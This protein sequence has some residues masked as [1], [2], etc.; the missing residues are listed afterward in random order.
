MQVNTGRMALLEAIAHKR[1]VLHQFIYA[2]RTPPPVYSP[3]E[4][5]SRDLLRAKQDT[6]LVVAGLES[7]RKHLV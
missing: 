7:W 3:W 6:P 4:C 5:L 2:V 1:F